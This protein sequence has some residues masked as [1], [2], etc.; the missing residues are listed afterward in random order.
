MHHLDSRVRDDVGELLR[1][2]VSRQG[3][4]LSGQTHDAGGNCRR[5]PSIFGQLLIMTYI[6]FSINLLSRKFL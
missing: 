1:S 5:D 4:D 2:E 6:F 3:H